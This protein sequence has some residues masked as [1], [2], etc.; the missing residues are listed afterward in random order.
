MTKRTFKE[1]SDSLDCDK[2]TYHMYDQVYPLFLESKREEPIR[3]LE[4]GLDEGKSVK[5]WKEYLPL[6][7]VI[8]VD[9]LD[10]SHFGTDIFYQADQ[11]SWQD[12]C[13]LAE[14]VSSVDIII[15]DGSHVIP[16]QI[17]TF[18]AL[19][20]RCLAPGGVYIIEDIECSYWK[21][22][23]SIYGYSTDGSSLLD[24]FSNTQHVVNSHMNTL[25]NNLLIKSISYFQNAIV[26]QKQNSS[27]VHRANSPYRFAFN[28]KEM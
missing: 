25:E 24:Y 15:D 20:S 7:T 5:I 26:I 6:A 2:T 19:F 16:H 23:S 9:I 17:N 27:E 11:S 13:D 21:P 1:I 8:G 3:L 14:Q 4:I 10:K 12:M 28:I 18:E 22:G